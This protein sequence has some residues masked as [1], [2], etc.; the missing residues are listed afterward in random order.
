[1]KQKT[2]LLLLISVVSNSFSQNEK[3]GIEVNYP[4]FFDN[5]FIGENYSGIVD[6]G[7]SYSFINTSF[8]DFGTSFNTSILKDSNKGSFSEYDITVFSFQP[9]I[10]GEFKIISLDKFHPIARL[11]YTI[12]SFSDAYDF[13]T[14]EELE[15]PSSRTGFNLGIGI[16][17]RIFNKLFLKAEYDF[18]KLSQA[19]N[20]FDSKFNSNVNV[21]TFGLHYRL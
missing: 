2:I 11:G 19:S 8:A 14:G 3:F 16:A 9:T 15:S 20:F 6:L 13:S 4:V 1:M 21:L 17:Y 5:N 18:T 7:L 10:Y 12:L